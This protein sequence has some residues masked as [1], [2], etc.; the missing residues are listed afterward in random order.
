MIKIIVPFAVII[1][2]MV[3]KK[4][5]KI[6]GDVRF[7]L[8][9]GAL[10]ALLMGGV[11]NPVEWLQAGFSGLNNV[12]F[13]IWLIFFGALFSEVLVH[14]G[15][16]EA[17]LNFMRSTFGRT[18]KGLLV[19]M[20]LF[21]VVGGALFGDATAAV[22]IIGFLGINA[23]AELKLEPEQI[24]ASLVMGSAMGSIMPPISQATVLAASL[25]GLKDE[26]PAITLTYFTV[27]I[28]VILM[29]LYA[30]RWVKIKQLPEELIPKE[31]PKE[32]LRNTWGSMVSFVLLFVIVL[33]QS[34]GHNPIAFLDIAL[35]GVK[36]IPIIGG[37]TNKIVLAVVI[38]FIISF[39]YKPTRDHTG[40]IIKIGFRK[41]LLPEVI[42]VCSAFLIGAFRA[43]GQVAFMQEF[44]A[45]IQDSLLKL[46]GSFTMVMTGMITGLQSS[47]QTTIFTVLGPA[48]TQIGVTP[49]HATV[50]GAHLAMA[51]Q[52]LPPADMLTFL[53][54]GLV[55]GVIGKQINPMKSM[56]YSCPQCIYFI[57]VALVFLF[58]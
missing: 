32:I 27:G 33:F 23:L 9:L 21:C 4:I 25:V 11:Y 56:K 1:A 50:A 52:G 8:I 28:G 6:G 41:M 14:N 37:I 16:M 18:P 40:D 2:I 20:F 38:A 54:V 22:T 51:G 42:M 31:S 55:G 58:I 19:V 45:S 39:L 36:T 12:S 17:F 3:I 35:A 44:A 5:P 24:T 26:T 34:L 53:T 30:S 57:L 10:A 47:T 7:A 46:T 48:L 29:S 13:I 49:V 15:G 43:G